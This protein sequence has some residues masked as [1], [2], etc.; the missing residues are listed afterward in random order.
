MIPKQTFIDGSQAMRQTRTR[1]THLFYSGAALVLLAL[2]L[3][4]FQNFYL[5]GKAY[6]GR[7][8]AP[9]IRDLIILHGVAMSAWILLF[10]IQPLLV[11]GRQYSVHRL[12][13]K[14]GALLAASILFLG[15]KAAI[16][17][18]R[19]APPEMLIW[20]LSP[21][22]FLAVP[23]I[24]I[25][26]FAVFVASGV[27]YRKRSEVHRP[28]MLL[29]TLAAISAA[30]S[31]IDAVTALYSGTVWETIFGPFFGMLLVGAF[32]LVVKGVLTK[33][34][35][36]CYTLGYAGL[37]LTSA[38]TMMIAKTAIWQQFAAFLLR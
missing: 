11:A 14:I 25:V 24:S 18:T 38:L 37:I 28:M 4:G 33:S 36:R 29:A 34:W 7:E 1:H 35:N 19:I 15:I 10:L 23:I 13:G 21:P 22:Q 20:G 27:S 17:A 12:L 2:M 3:T 26:V 9:P 5:H 32:F 8:I 30:I 6:P 16:E 31:R